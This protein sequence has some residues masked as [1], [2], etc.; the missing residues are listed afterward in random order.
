MQ[1]FV[2]YNSTVRA[3]EI[4]AAASDDEKQAAVME[5]MEWRDLATEVAQVD[6]GLPL[7]PLLNITSDHTKPSDTTV[8]GYALVE[9]RSKD[10]LIELL[11]THPHLKRPGTSIDL[12]EMIPLDKM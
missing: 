10:D 1:Y 7:H 12:L 9:S 5:W 6:F 4:M 11:K 2:L 3:K 8:V